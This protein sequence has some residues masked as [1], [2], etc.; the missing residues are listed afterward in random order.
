MK[1]TLII[2]GLV[3]A[4]ISSFAQ[5][6][7]NFQGGLNQVKVNTNSTFVQM[8][9]VNVTLLFSTASVLPAVDGIAMQ[10]AGSG[11]LSSSFVT[12]GT[13]FTAATAWAAILGDG[14]YF[15][16]NGTGAQAS[17]AVLAQTAGT[18]AWVYNASSSYS[19]ANVTAG[20]TY[21][22]YVVAWIGSETTLAAA[23]AAGDALGWS[24][25][26]Q[27]TP[28]SGVTGATST[29]GL[30]GK[31]AVYAPIVAAP[32]PSTMALAALGGASLLL[33]RRRK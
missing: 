19:A 5:G 32:E 2:A 30:E 17:S 14:N 25:S 33:F 11:A 16:V 1:K 27:Y 7:V 20:T 28:T 4:G 29:S 15:Q 10:N 9:G 6:N 26:F 8:S 3:L 21:Y 12:N 22:A 13:T 24:Q 23:A 31:F 18:G